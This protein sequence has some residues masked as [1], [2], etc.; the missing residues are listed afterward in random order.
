MKIS[1][2][3]LTF[4]A[5]TLAA[6]A[7]FAAPPPPAQQPANPPTKTTMRAHQAHSMS[8]HSMSGGSMPSFNKLDTNHTGYLSTK[9]AASVP[10]LVTDWKG[11]DTNHDGKISRS[12][13][14]AWEH[15]N[16]RTNMSKHPPRHKAHKTG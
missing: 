12:E 11:A 10:G 13:Y 8:K 1:V 16:A 7:A 3:P 15:H 2:I 14:M 4:A 6:G 9:E 5:A